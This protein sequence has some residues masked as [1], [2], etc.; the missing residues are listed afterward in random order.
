MR[1]S[2][3]SRF[4]SQSSSSSRGAT[5]STSS[6]GRLSS[7]SGSSS[8]FDLE[9][10]RS[11]FLATKEYSRSTT[12]SNR[13][14]KYKYYPSESVSSSWYSYGDDGISTEAKNKSS[15]RRKKTGKSSASMPSS[16]AF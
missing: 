16:I 1:S 8:C 2:G 7:I 3:S 11:T 10:D 4:S 6:S 5:S 12:T 15:L 9:S 14:T 13:T